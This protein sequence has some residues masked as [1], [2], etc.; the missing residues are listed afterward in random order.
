MIC[1]ECK[2]GRLKVTNTHNG[3]PGRVAQRR[4]CP[5]CHTVFAVACTVIKSNPQRGQ[6][7]ETLARHWRLE[8]VSARSED[9]GGAQGAQ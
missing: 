3:G 2:T 4:Y 8:Q 5:L 6:G 7:A 1:P 9:A